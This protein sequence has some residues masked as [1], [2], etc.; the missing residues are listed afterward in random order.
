MR[1]PTEVGCGSSLWRAVL[2]G[3]VPA[4]LAAR[5]RVF[6]TGHGRKTDAT[7]AHSIAMVRCAPAGC[8]SWPPMRSWRCCGCWPTAATSCP[9]VGTGR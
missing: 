2:P 3:T 1:L 9:A 8:G 5:V 4:K 6:D 7:D